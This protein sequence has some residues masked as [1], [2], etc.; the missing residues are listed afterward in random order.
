M[1][2]AGALFKAGKLAVIQGVGYP[3]PDR[4]HF[5]S[6]EIWHTAS[7]AKKVPYTGWLGRVLDQEFAP[8]D[9]ELGRAGAE[10]LP[11]ELRHP[12]G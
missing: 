2:E 3:E 4:S 7:T 5:R 1:G 12:F 8:G 6:M 11:P 9:E 10:N